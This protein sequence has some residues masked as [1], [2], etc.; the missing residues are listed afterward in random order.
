MEIRVAII[1]GHVLFREGLASLLHAYSGLS[2]TMQADSL[3]DFSAALESRH[4]RDWPDAII[5][6]MMSL[7]NGHAHA[8]QAFLEQY[9]CFRRLIVNVPT[10]PIPKHQLTQL[11]AEY[12]FLKN[13][14]IQEIADTLYLARQAQYIYPNVTLVSEEEMQMAA[15]PHNLSRREIEVI[16]CLC[17]E[18]TSKQIAAKLFISLKTVGHHRER[19]QKKIGVVS[20]AGIVMYAVRNKIV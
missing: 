3:G 19:I 11:E 9:P 16:R 6:D 5:I 17:L 1:D 7:Q 20:T 18:Y 13:S 12:Y 14:P 15:N 10:D 2:V 8:A 4:M